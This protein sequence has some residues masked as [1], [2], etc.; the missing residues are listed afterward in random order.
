MID[1]ILYV[2]DF[3]ALVGHLDTHYPAML[4]RDDKGAI[5]QPPVVNGFARTPAAMM[6]T[7]L[8][9]YARLTIEQADQWRGMAGVRVLAEAPFE[10]PGTTDAV[11]EA[12]F[13]DTEAAAIYNRV[14]PHEP[15]TIS[16]PDMGEIT[17]TPPVRFGA[18]AG[19]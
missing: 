1:A 12:L 10:G 4:E 7:E 13:A 15:Y 5:V 3:P 18:M 8:M 19:G 11:Y 2:A 16:D 14:Y 17:V 6:G 9:V